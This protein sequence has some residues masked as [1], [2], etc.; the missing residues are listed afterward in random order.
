MRPD[1]HAAGQ[2]GWCLGAALTAAGTPERAVAAMLDSFGGAG[3]VL[4]VD[5]PAAAADLAAAQ[6]AAGDPDGADA[7]ARRSAGTPR[8]RA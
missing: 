5:R 1:F 7:D 3:A 8:S 4:P 6:L 2:P